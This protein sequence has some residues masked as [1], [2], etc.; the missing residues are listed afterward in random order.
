MTR[1][2]L[3]LVL[4]LAVGTALTAALDLFWRADLALYDA[5]L[6]HRAAAPDII[7]IAIDEKSLQALGRWPWRRNLHAQLLGRLQ[8]AGAAGVALDLVMTEPDLAHP[9]DDAALAAA[10]A[11]GPP[12]VLPTL[13][14]LADQGGQPRALEPLPA[15]A[16]TA[17]AL[18]HADVE[19]DRDGIARSVFLR[20]GPGAPRYAHLMLA[21]LQATSGRRATQPFGAR[22][23][24]MTHDSTAWVRDYQLLIPY[25]GAPGSFTQYSYVDVLENRVPAEQLRGRFVLVGA[26][27]QGLGDAYPTPFSGY[28]SAMPGVE[29]CANILQALESR[30]YIRPAPKAWVA[31]LAPLPL[32]L[33]C[34]ILYRHTPRQ[35]LFWLIS[36]WV[37]VL[38]ASIAAVRLAHWWWPPSA[39]LASLTLIYPLWG[40]WRLNA[41]HHYLDAEFD[42]FRSERMPFG[43]FLPDSPAPQRFADVLQQRIEMLRAAAERM[44]DSHRLLVAT[45]RRLPDATLI[46]DCAGRIIA[47]NHGAATLFD[48]DDEARLEGRSVDELFRSLRG[49]EQTSHQAIHDAAPCS[50]EVH[51]EHSGRDLLV[52]AEPFLI[53][54]HARLGTLI[55]LADV[56]DLRAMQKEREDIVSFVSHD[57]KTP[58]SALLA[59]AQLQR[60]PGRELAPAELTRRFEA[61]AQRTLLL[62]NGFTALAQAELANPVVFIEFDL[63]DAIQDACDEVWALQES[64]GVQLATTL[65]DMPVVVLGDQRLL[66]RAITNLLNNA[67]KYSPA[68]STICLRC[69]CRQGR[70]QVSVEDQGSGVPSEHRASLFRRFS[71]ARHARGKD[72]GGL[73]LGLALVRVVAQRHRGEVR[74]EAA[75]SGGARFIFTIPLA[76]PAG[77]TMGNSTPCD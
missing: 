56:T 59:L 60:T 24:A 66:A 62:L 54:P 64:R 21:L 69:E 5:S 2:W 17:A 22:N 48:A 19:L 55:S 23:P 75:D 7:I 14:E 40:W 6:P 10:L 27:A 47:G 3:L 18:G 11:S 38:A 45:V 29:I 50:F 51:A 37:A 20:E 32:L 15:L 44:R 77:A 57:L 53:N 67:V 41:M 52:R 1:S 4:A 16:R 30:T 49:V 43:G 58:A 70:T 33:V 76:S 68:G 73:G 8:T 26:T 31:A 74:Y 28:S 63:R 13:S 39:S 25:I 72:P 46:T 35:S 61:L 34:W 42:R 9:D 12:T 71:R 36:I 65:P